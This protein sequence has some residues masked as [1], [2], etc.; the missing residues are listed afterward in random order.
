MN[1]HFNHPD[2]Q[3]GTLQQPSSTQHHDM[4][5]GDSSEVT[6]QPSSQWTPHPLQ[7]LPYH[8]GNQQQL[9]DTVSSLINPRPSAVPHQHIPPSDRTLP[10][11]QTLSCPSEG[12]QTLIE[13]PQESSSLS[14][15]SQFTLNL[16]QTAPIFNSVIPGPPPLIRMELPSLDSSPTREVSSQ[17]ASP[18]SGIGEQSSI[19]QPYSSSCLSADYSSQLTQHPHFSQ[20]PLTQNPHQIQSYGPPPQISQR[21]TLHSHLLPQPRDLPRTFS[22]PSNHF[23]INRQNTHTQLLPKLNLMCPH[24]GL[25]HNQYDSLQH[26][27]SR[28]QGI[29]PLMSTECSLTTNSLSILPHSTLAI[30]YAPLPDYTTSSVGGRLSI[31][32]D[33]PVPKRPCPSPRITHSLLEVEHTQPSTVTLCSAVVGPSTPH[34][35]KIPTP[36]NSYV[37]SSHL[38]SQNHS[39]SVYSVAS[40]SRSVP[41]SSKLSLYLAYEALFP[42]SSNWHN[43]GLALGLSESTLKTIDYYYRDCKDCLRETLALR[44]TEKMLTWRDII[45]ALRSDIVKNNELNLFIEINITISSFISQFKSFLLPSICHSKKYLVVKII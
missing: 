23:H 20:P 41:V 30:Q 3:T 37:A 6:D 44:I 29:V 24:P 22:Q 15:D 39:L 5:H 1:Q 42:V 11:P 43:L 21:P 25:N 12:I 34:W 4:L 19:Q 45:S 10:P 40:Q 8:H 26:V 16:H 28:T 17:P 2:S 9:Q 31:N 7:D 27:E 33:V 38:R 18:F 14:A 36:A 13:Q 32:S 35:Q